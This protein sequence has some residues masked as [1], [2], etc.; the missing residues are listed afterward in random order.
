MQRSPQHNQISNH[1]QDNIVKFVEEQ[2]KKLNIKIEQNELEIVLS[3]FN[4]NQNKTI[5]SFKNGDA[6]N[7]LSGWTLTK[8]KKNVQYHSKTSTP[9]KYLND[10]DSTKINSNVYNLKNANLNDLNLTKNESNSVTIS[11]IISTTEDSYSL[12]EKKSCWINDDLTK[13]IQSHKE[14]I[15]KYEQKMEHCHDSRLL[16]YYIKSANDTRKQITLLLN[17]HQKRLVD[18]KIVEEVKNLSSKVDTISKQNNHRLKQELD[19]WERSSLRTKDEQVD[20]KN[21]LI[22]YYNCGGINTKQIRCM[23]LNKFFDRSL[24]RAAHIW[25]VATRGVG[26]PEF[27]L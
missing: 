21:S 16:N 8:K 5:D 23:V 4:F 10:C 27:S 1:V 18:T 24:V 26:L 20:F 14:S 13:I 6:N 15:E 11:Q 19:C 22:V 12:D 7:I 17:V 3:Y 9:L 2:L 25:K